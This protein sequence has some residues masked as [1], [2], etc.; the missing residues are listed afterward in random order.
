[1]SRVACLAAALLQLS[2]A[3]SPP[4]LLL[5][6][7]ADGGGLKVE[8]VLGSP[9][10][11][12]TTTTTGCWVECVAQVEGALVPSQTVNQT[13]S[14]D[15]CVIVLSGV[16][17]DQTYAVSCLL[18]TS[19][20]A[21]YVST[22]PPIKTV[23]RKKID[24]TRI[25]LPF[26]IFIGLGLGVTLTV[27]D[28]KEAWVQRRG[29][30]VGFAAQFLINPLIGLLFQ[31]IFKFSEAVAVGL[32]LVAAAPGGSTSNLF[33]FW[34]GGNVALSVGM[35]ACSTIAALGMMPLWLYLLAS[36]YDIQI[37]YFSLIGGLLIMLFPLGL[38]ILIRKKNT[39]MRFKGMLISKWIEKAGSIGGAIFLLLALIIGLVDN[40]D[41]LTSPPPVWI[42]A[43]LFQPTTQLLGF[44]MAK[45]VRMSNSNARTIS[46]ETGVQ[47]SVLSIAIAGI[48]F[49]NNLEILA[50]VSTFP[51][52]Y[53]M[54][55]CVNSP[56]TVY[57][58]RRWALAEGTHMQLQKN[59]KV[60]PFGG[61]VDAF[62]EGAAV[63][64]ATN[65]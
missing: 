32:Y 24:M 29:I 51:L 38:G 1:M 44:C 17:K 55:Y 25:L 50:E 26:L 36:D 18:S 30:I 7:L 65:A 5:N 23:P 54:S 22:F 47:N 40:T 3:S 63:A 43:F 20:L 28:F 56:V 41:L 19:S 52:M 35:S 12:T 61:Y 42:T 14:G 62:Q 37:D 48:T 59:R 39:V 33:T 13:C 21:G 16:P 53:S 27:E 58:F 15:P 11:A 10:N 60:A 31:T 34:S 64:T 46:M 4:D 2:L 45:A 9:C 49:S 6:P 57:L 8:A